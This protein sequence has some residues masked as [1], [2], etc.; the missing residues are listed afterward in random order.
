MDYRILGPLELADGTAPI[1]VTGARQRA[2][3]ALLLIHRNEVVSSERIV[4]ALWGAT[5][6]ASAAKAVQNAVSQ[7]RRALAGGGDGALRTERG[8]YVLRVAPGELD[9]DRF[10]A[11]L[12]SGRRSLTAGDAAPAAEELRHALA[13][14][15]GPALADVAYD[16]FAQ[17]E[18]ARLEELR[19]EALEE[20]VDADLALGR[21]DE[22][23]AEL[24]AEI[25]RHP[26]RE[27]LRGQQMLALYRSGRQADALEAFQDA[28]RLLVDEL[29]IEPGPA[30]RQRHEAIL[31]QDPS[32]DAAYRRSPARPTEAPRRRDCAGAA[33]GRR[34]A[35]LAAAVAVALV[36]AR[37]G[38]QLAAAR[39]GAVPGNSLVA[40]DPRN[41]NV[42][43]SY[44]TGSTPTAVTAGRSG[45]WALNGDDRTLTGVD[46]RTSA[47]RTFAVPDTPLGIAAGAE[48]VWALTGTP[49]KHVDLVVVP[50]RL[51]EL[52]PATG[53]R[54]VRS[55]CRSRGTRG[56]SRSTA[57]RWRATDCGSSAPAS[58]C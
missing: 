46:T 25:A 38:D 7:V 33:C 58:G 3:L 26:L 41:G 1:E 44:P 6:P 8:G 43:A 29:G 22:L 20:R 51:V 15:R 16:A 12:E 13:L 28:R 4:D 10:E 48:S 21:H 52:S 2:L 54:C 39:L 36:S 17:P 37:G 24:E 14:W 9:A 57:S 45:I 18:I 23:E 56:A 49:G 31:Q 35:L 32:L 55:S 30:L 11:L 53:V 5:P 42:V 40:L 19:L 34:R 47:T 27:R 50:R